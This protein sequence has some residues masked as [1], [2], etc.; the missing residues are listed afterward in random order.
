MNSEIF[1][2]NVEIPENHVILG[3]GSMFEIRGNLL[4]MGKPEAAAT[5]LGVGRAAFEKAL[6]YSRKRVQGG[7]PIA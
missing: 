7:K 3:E 4:A 1:Y 2:E 6:D 5:V